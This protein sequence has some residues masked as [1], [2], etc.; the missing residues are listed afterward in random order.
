M[1]FK[2]FACVRICCMGHR[3]AT[4]DV[5]NLTFVISKVKLRKITTLMFMRDKQ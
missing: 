4:F 2:F 3:F 5:C 1:K